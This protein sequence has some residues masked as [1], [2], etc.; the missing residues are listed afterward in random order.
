MIDDGSTLQVGYGGIP[1]A[2]VMQLA[3]KHDLRFTA[4]APR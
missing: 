1:D 2:V 3:H 4:R